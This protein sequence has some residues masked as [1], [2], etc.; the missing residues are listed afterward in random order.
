MNGGFVESYVLKE[1]CD[2][3]IIITENIKLDTLTKTENSD[4]FNETVEKIQPSNT[5]LLST[6]LELNVYVLFLI[7][8]LYYPLCQIYI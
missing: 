3:D 1:N 2:E 5:A 7:F 8:C 4:V 6:L